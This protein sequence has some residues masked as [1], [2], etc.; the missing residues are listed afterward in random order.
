MTTSSRARVRVVR[1]PWNVMARLAEVVGRNGTCL[2]IVVISV[3][4]GRAPKALRETFV[5]TEASLGKPSRAS[6]GHLEL[7]PRPWWSLGA[8]RPILGGP[9]A[10]SEKASVRDR[11]V[12]AHA[13]CPGN[14]SGRA[15][16]HFDTVR[17][18]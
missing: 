18:F 11:G 1:N 7:V 17:D 12:P 5:T 3:L 6:E 2:G 16:G 8:C 15:I 10:L 14:A 4:H 9:G 13:I